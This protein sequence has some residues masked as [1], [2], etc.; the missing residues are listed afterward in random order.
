MLFSRIY[1]IVLTWEIRTIAD[2]V[3]TFN[4][5]LYVVR[6]EVVRE[7]KF[8]VGYQEESIGI[9]ASRGHKKGTTRE[10]CQAAGEQIV[11]G[12]KV[13]GKV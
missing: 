4:P 7:E 8:I 1:A 9:N 13:M 10:E 11:K 6:T 2:V 12:R 5:Q 3:A